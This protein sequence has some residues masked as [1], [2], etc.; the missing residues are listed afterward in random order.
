MDLDPTVSASSRAGGPRWTTVAAAATL[1]VFAALAI[2]SAASRS[3]VA[4]ELGGHIA[5]GYLFWKSGTFSGGIANFPLAQLILAAPVAWSSADYTLFTEQHL[6]WFRLPVVL[7]AVGLGVLIHRFSGQRHGAVAALAS[8]ALFAFSPNFLAHG[9]LATLDLA[10][11]FFVFATAFALWRYVRDPR[12]RAMLWLSLTLAAALATKV[13]ALALLPWIAVVLCVG[14]AGRLP[15][16]LRPHWSWAMLLVVPWMFLHLVYWKAPFVDGGVLPRLYLDALAFKLSHGAGSLSELQFA[17]LWGSY[18][19]EGWWYYFPVAMVLKTPLPT[20]LSIG[21]GVMR[22]HDRLDLLLLVLP[23]VTLLGAAMTTS[24]NIGIR[25]VLLVYPFLFVLAGRG[26]AGLWARPRARFVVPALAAG[27]VFSVATTTPRFLSYFNLATG[28]SPRGHL[29]LVDSNFDWG[30]NDRELAEYVRETG[31][32]FQIDPDPFQPTTGRILVNA[33]AYYG[34]YGGG[35]PAAY[36]WLKGRKMDAQIADTW[37]EF[38]VPEGA[39]PSF[40]PGHRAERVGQRNLFRP[41]N[42]TVSTRQLDALLDETTGYLRHL[43]TRWADIEDP[44]T[45]L[46][47]AWAFAFTADYASALDVLRQ[48]LAIDPAHEQALGL[49]GEL[50]VQWKLGVLRFRGLD[51]LNDPGAPPDAPPAAADPRRAANAALRAG[52]GPPLAQ[53]H[54][55]L[56]AHLRRAGRQR[57]ADV[58]YQDALLFVPPDQRSRLRPPTP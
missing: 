18:S 28:G 57:E 7:L 29:H 5:G 36:A 6:L 2:Y 38:D 12:P 39:R 45:L 33:N 37:F 32:A 31:G 23:A 22:R 1:V 47:L 8:V 46:P 52:V 13:Q 24:I 42:D 51:Y 15:T 21:A 17:Y 26:V 14:A 4:D 9:S 44:E 43:R 11:A 27:L 53:T 3:A 16:R 10:I 56:Y 50:M 55:A 58:L 40:P 41:W 20:L 34:I 25:H 19:T 48:I 35:G 49:G 54:L 30:Q